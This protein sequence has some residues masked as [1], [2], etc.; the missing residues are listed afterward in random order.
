ME[1]N[2]VVKAVYRLLL[3]FHLLK[4]IRLPPCSNVYCLKRASGKGDWLYLMHKSQSNGNAMTEFHIDLGKKNLKTTDE[5]F[6]K[7]NF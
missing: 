6:L 3:C 2:F 4:T 1:L 7:V 5:S